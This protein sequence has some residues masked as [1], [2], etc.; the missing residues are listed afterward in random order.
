MPYSPWIA[1]FDVKRLA[2]YLLIISLSLEPVPPQYYPNMEVPRILHLPNTTPNS[3]QSERDNR[4][5]KC[6]C[7]V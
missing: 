3:N 2:R 4:M 1:F 6:E 7:T 5:A